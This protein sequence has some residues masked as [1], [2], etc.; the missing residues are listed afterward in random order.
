MRQS[1]TSAK[2]KIWK[3][4]KR[5]LFDGDKT[6][7]SN[8]RREFVDAYAYKPTAREKN[9]TAEKRLHLDGAKTIPSKLPS[10]GVQNKNN[11]ALIITYCFGKRNALL[12]SFAAMGK[13]KCPVAARA[14]QV[15]PAYKMHTG[16]QRTKV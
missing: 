16:I 14:A 2:E 15:K 12:L 13:R 11:F 3:V 9:S 6:K 10:E 5:L 4:V 7:P 1:H 8:C